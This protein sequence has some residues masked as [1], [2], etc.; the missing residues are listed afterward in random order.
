MST[1]LSFPD[2][3]DFIVVHSIKFTFEDINN[4]VKTFYARV[5][6]DDHLH[7]PFS[8]V[9]DWPHH[10]DKLTHFWWFRFGGDP[11]MNVQYDPVTRHFE[12]GFSEGLLEIWLNLF[13]DVLNET[14]T[15]AQADL[16]FQFAEGMGAALNRNNEM[17]KLREGIK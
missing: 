17:M 10:I 2:K 16:W 15:P 11:Y 1:P 8:V 6:V 13:K 7:G 12:T 14:L 3:N 5:E 4:V 9:D